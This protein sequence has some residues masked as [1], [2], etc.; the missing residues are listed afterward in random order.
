MTRIEGQQHR[1]AFEKKEFT[2]LSSKQLKN[3]AAAA[4]NVFN[5]ASGVGYSQ[6]ELDPSNPLN[7]EGS[8]R[9]EELPPADISADSL[10]KQFGLGRPV[11]ARSEGKQELK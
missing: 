5:N 9:S 11:E 8:Q 1:F 6:V 3:I 4:Q 10:A 2:K 7:S